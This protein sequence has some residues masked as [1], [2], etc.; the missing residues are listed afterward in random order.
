MASI[1]ESLIQQELQCGICLDTY[2]N[3]KYVGACHHTFC[4][5]CLEGVI[6]NNKHKGVFPCPTCRRT[7]SIPYDG[8]A[9]LQND[10]RAVSLIRAL[11]AAQ[12]NKEKSAADTESPT[13][14]VCRVSVATRYCEECGGGIHLC[15]SC[16]E[17][18]SRTA[19]TSNHKIIQIQEV[20]DP[21]EEPLKLYC[22]TCSV[23]LCHV[24]LLADHS[25]HD[26]KDRGVLNVEMKEQIEKSFAESVEL[27][28]QLESDGKAIHSL[29]TKIKE[30]A[31]REKE[32]RQKRAHELQAMLAL[33]ERQI[34]DLQ[35]RKKELWNEISCE[36]RS[37]S[38]WDWASQQLESLK[39]DITSVTADL[40]ATQQKVW[41][42]KDTD[43]TTIRGEDQLVMV[44]TRLKKNVDVARRTR[45]TAFDIAENLS[46]A[47]AEGKGGMHVSS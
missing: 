42:L 24:C 22:E 13:C 6:R 44:A 19:A 14:R 4:S 39:D 25:E 17:K 21:H 30:T 8:A 10:F 34:D 26:V 23:R 12:P 35:R 36:A 11:K 18:H 43:L 2:N 5:Q 15:T 38:E 33:V 31:K 7:Y 20:C 9:G 40:D 27:K 28:K 1:D 46:K 29:E 16:S 47:V 45:Q 32:A 3:P 37:G 41:G